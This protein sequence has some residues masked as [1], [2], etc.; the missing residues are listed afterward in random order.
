MMICFQS[1]WCFGFPAVCEFSPGDVPAFSQLCFSLPERCDSQPIYF[2]IFAHVYQL[3]LSRSRHDPLALAG[4]AG[5]SFLFR[6]PLPARSPLALV[7]PAGSTLAMDT[8]L[9]ACFSKPQPDRAGKNF[10]FRVPLPVSRPASFRFLRAGRL[11]GCATRSGDEKQ[12][13]YVSGRTLDGL[14]YT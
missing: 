12:F 8:I 6:V 3:F 14:R 13:Y 9:P 5:M 10:L 2:T 4:Q 11:M 1:L 7:S